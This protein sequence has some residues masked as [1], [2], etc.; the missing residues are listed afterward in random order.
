MNRI[1]QRAYSQGRWFTEVP[2]EWMAAEFFSE[3]Y[4]RA[5]FE[6]LTNRFTEGGRW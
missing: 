4:R 2:A 6:A 3:E 5:V 1:G